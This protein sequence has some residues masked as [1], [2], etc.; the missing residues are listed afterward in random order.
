M[1]YTVSGLLCQ[2]WDKNSPHDLTGKAFV[3]D[4]SNFPS[5]SQKKANNYCRNPDP[6]WSDGVWCFTM[7][8]N[9]ERELCPV[10]WC[11]QCLFMFESLKV[12]FHYPSSRPEF[13]GRELW[14][15]F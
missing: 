5:G 10:P 15:I 4:A 3:N 8:A 6:N 2:R 13:T 1:D 12:G 11:G 14:C 7:D 9:V